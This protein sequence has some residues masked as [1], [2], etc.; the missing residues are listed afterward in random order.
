MEVVNILVTGII[1]TPVVVLEGEGR[2]G[3]LQ[4]IM[5]QAFVTWLASWDTYTSLHDLYFYLRVEQPVG[6]VSVG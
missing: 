5:I 6:I 2:I 3:H 4:A 1:T